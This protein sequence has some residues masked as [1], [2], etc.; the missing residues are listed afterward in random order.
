MKNISPANNSTLAIS[1]LYRL[2]LTPSVH[3]L[4]T[5]PAPKRTSLQHTP[6]RFRYDHS[7]P[8]AEESEGLLPP[9]QAER[10]RLWRHDALM[11][12]H[13]TTACCVG[14]KVYALT[15]DPNDAFWLAQAYYSTGDFRRAHA[16]VAPLVQSVSCRYLAALC[17]TKLSRWEEALD[18]LGEENPFRDAGVGVKNQDGGIRLEASMCYLRGVIYANQNNFD[19]AKECYKEAVLADVKCYEAFNELVSNSFLTPREEWELLEQLD[20]S[21]LDD[22]AE[23]IKNLYITRLNKYIH[24][25]RITAAE[26]VLAEDYGLEDN[27]DVLVSKAN[28]LFIQCRFQ[29]C[30]AVCEKLLS[31][32]EF[33]FQALPIYLSVLHELGGKNKLFLAANRL[34]EAYPK[35]CTSWLAIGI[36]YLS[37]GRVSEARKFFSKASLANPNFGQAWIGFAHTFATEGEHEQAVT[38]YSTVA[39]LFPGTH[40]PNLF[41][42]MQYLQMS[43]LLLAE[44]YM[45]AAYSVCPEDPLLLNEIG[46][47]HFHGGDLQKSEWF[48]LRAFSESAHLTSDSKLWVSVNSNLGHVYRK[49]GRYEQAL[50]RF[51]EVLKLSVRD[52]NIYAAIGLVYLK[53]GQYFKS[54][55]ALHNA[56]AV[57]PNDPIANDLLKRALNQNASDKRVFKEKRSDFAASTPLPKRTG[58]LPEGEFFL[59]TEKIFGLSKPTLEYRRASPFEGDVSEVAKGLMRGEESSDEMDL[60]SD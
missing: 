2:P 50:A 59:K 8:V 44:E 52:A 60:E 18:V 53:T 39:R 1:P 31:K 15:N 21:E 36:Y 9:T 48:F 33:N 5:P 17:L 3:Q 55:E 46:V 10:L 13:Y 25:S 41:L 32:D 12:H 23:L 24:V 35:S 42:G 43:N 20:F 19:R 29:E 7:S 27:A 47:V 40:L 16:L 45:M 28:L 11:Q 37:V 30:L 4:H 54:I 56:L 51:Q 58:S 38:A 34:A 49:M 6:E 22:N 26:T 57:S 14:D